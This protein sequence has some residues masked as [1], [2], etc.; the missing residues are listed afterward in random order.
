MAEAIAGAFGIDWKSLVEKGVLHTAWQPFYGE[1]LDEVGYRLLSADKR[2]G[3]KRLFIDGFGA[4]TA[5]PAYAERGAGFF[6]ALF[7]SYG[8]S[9]RRRFSRCNWDLAAGRSS[10]PIT[11]YPRSPTIP[12]ISPR[13]RATM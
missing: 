1:S 5:T 6:A 9:G 3:A 10:F 13:K 7:W 8:A 11:T 2:T 12:C 4:V